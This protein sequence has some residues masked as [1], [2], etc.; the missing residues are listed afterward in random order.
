MKKIIT[1]KEEYNSL[2]KLQSYLKTASN[3]SS[4]I[5]HD[6]WEMKKD[7]AGNM[8]KCL[9]V[10]KSAMHGV[11]VYFLDNKTI[12]LSYAIPNALLHAWFGKSQQ[13]YRRIDEIVLGKIKDAVL[14][15]SQKKVFN[16]MEQVF[17]GAIA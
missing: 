14:A 4:N 7:A 9:M 16:E 11:K 17:K 10:K 3:Y 13:A 6:K 5:Q 8:L 2:E 1:I 12:E 15:G